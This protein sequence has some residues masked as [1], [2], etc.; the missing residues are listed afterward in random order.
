[1]D[2]TMEVDSGMNL[3]ALTRE[4]QEFGDPQGISSLHVMRTH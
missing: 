2:E 1:M 3:Q 4:T